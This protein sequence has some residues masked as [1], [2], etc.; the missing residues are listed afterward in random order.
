MARSAADPRRR[1]GAAAVVVV[2]LLAAV[3]CDPPAPPPGPPTG[4]C[5]P[6]PFTAEVVAILDAYGAAAH[7]LTAAVYDDRSGCWYQF[8]PGVRV[9]TA[10]VVKMEIMAGVL[11]RAQD[12]G[13]GLTRWEADRVAPM[14][15]DSNDAAASA[16]WT[17]L[18][19]GPGMAAVGARFGL[20][21]TVE[22]S[23]VWGLTSTTAFDQARFVHTLLQGPGPLDAA[24][25][26]LAWLYL[27]NIRPDQRWG[28]R[29]GVPA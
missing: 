2:L 3:A 11:L 15:S 20:D 27:R 1:T 21:D 8:R 22:T 4:T 29:S 18:G 16:L 14:I 13:R 25:R 23:P 19:G 7:H 26:G 24:H 28:V 12:Q 5:R 17:S 9:T 10:S 6:D